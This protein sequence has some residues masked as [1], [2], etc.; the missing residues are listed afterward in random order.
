MEKFLIIKKFTPSVELPKGVCTP[1]P[2]STLL[3]GA[4][5][6]RRTLTNFASLYSDGA[7]KG[8]GKKKSI[9]GAGAV[10]FDKDKEI[11]GEYREFLGYGV[12]NN[13]A[14]YKA[15]ILGLKKAIEHGVTSIHAFVDSKL[16]CEQVKRNY[17]INKPHLKVLFEEV[18][19]LK[20]QFKFFRIVS[21]LRKY[22]SHA[23]RLANEAVAIG[24]TKM[25]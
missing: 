2:N 16:V 18:I 5:R 1:E 23:D 9:S 6:Q 22:N 3:P 15:L 17:K 8:N 14:E 13:V 25:N 21:V 19:K 24:H 7:C 11:I 4:P 12:T 20:E 10:L